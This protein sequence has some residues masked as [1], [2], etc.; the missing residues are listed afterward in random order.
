VDSKIYRH[1]SNKT[2]GPYPLVGK[3]FGLFNTPMPWA[4]NSMKTVKVCHARDK[5]I[6]LEVEA[7]EFIPSTSDAKCRLPFRLTDLDNSI[8]AINDFVGRSVESSVNAVIAEDDDFISQPFEMALEMAR[9]P[10][11]VSEQR[12]KGGHEETRKTDLCQDPL[13]RKLLH[14]F[15]AVRLL[16]GNWTMCGEDNLGAECLERREWN[17]HG[18]VRLP[19]FIDYQV[20][21][22]LMERILPKMTRNLLEDL[23]KMAH[24]P[25]N[26]RHKHWFRLQ[27]ACFI[28]LHSYELIMEHE[29]K[30]SVRRRLPVRRALNA[31]QS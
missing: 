9:E 20:A 10:N 25:K 11:P 7:R 30:Y 8:K 2:S 3:D 14:C 15:T 12:R 28:L 16:E 5:N 1:G 29:C 24:C 27:L 18:W 4:N 21:S 13:M 6:V 19:P 22:I 26:V 17:P 31:A 23:D